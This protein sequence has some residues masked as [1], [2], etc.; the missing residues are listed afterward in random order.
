M[1]LKKTRSNRRIY[2]VPAVAGALSL[3]ITNDKRASVLVSALALCLLTDWAQQHTLR[4]AGMQVALRWHRLIGSLVAAM[5]GISA[6]W[7]DDIQIWQA[8]AAPLAVGVVSD[9]SGRRIPH[10]LAGAGCASLLATTVVLHFHAG[11][12]RAHHW[13]IVEVMSFCILAAFLLIAQKSRYDIRQWWTW[14]VSGFILAFAVLLVAAL[15]ADTQTWSRGVVI[16][17]ASYTFFSFLVGVISRAFG[18]GDIWYMALCFLCLTSLEAMDWV[19]ANGLLWSYGV[20]IGIVGMVVVA[21]E[22]RHIENDVPPKRAKIKQLTGYSV[23][24]APIFA[25]AVLLAPVFWYQVF[26]LRLI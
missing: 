25:I 15:F 21:L 20:G 5:F 4:I 17:A 2:L 26:T 23:P 7:L 19:T 1:R 14:T 10:F 16:V 3:A 8:V 9:L 6:F 13:P 12:L 11:W 22:V 24:G 18:G